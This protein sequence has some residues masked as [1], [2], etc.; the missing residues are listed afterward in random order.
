[1]LIFYYSFIASYPF[2]LCFCKLFIIDLVLMILIYSPKFVRIKVC[3]KNEFL[4]FKF[5]SSG[6]LILLHK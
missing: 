6:Y 5:V 2:P 1:M 4:D 3:H